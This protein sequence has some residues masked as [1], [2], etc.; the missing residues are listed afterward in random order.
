MTEVLKLFHEEMPE[1]SVVTSSQASPQL[2]EALSKGT[3]DAAVLRREDT[4]Q[5]LAFELLAKDALVVILP[6]EHRLAS[7]TAIGPGFGRRTPGRG[8]PDSAHT[9]AVVD[10]YFERS[11][12]KVTTAHRVDHIAMAMSLVVSTQGVSLLPA[13]TKAFLPKSLTSR[14]LIGDPPTIEVVL[15]YR[16]TNASPVLRWLLSRLDELVSRVGP[17]RPR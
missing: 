16:K 15:G 9:R 2:A 10:D 11:G 1:V 13:Y 3:V 5:D 7:M 8:F 14:P 17:K 6:K 12:V 4:V